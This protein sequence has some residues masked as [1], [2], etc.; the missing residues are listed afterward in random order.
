MRLLK[1]LIHLFFW[2]FALTSKIMN[3]AWK[4]DRL[5]GFIVSVI[6]LPI[7]GPYIVLL[8][9]IAVVVQSVRFVQRQMIFARC[10]EEQR[11]ALNRL[12]YSI[13]SF[14]WTSKVDADDPRIT[15]ISDVEEAVDLCIVTG[16]AH[17]DLQRYVPLHWKRIQQRLAI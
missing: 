6:L 5:L 3:S 4:F 9:A 13:S 15:D 1:L 16:V 11:E 7:W 17:R 2:P 12:E 14:R 10:T 8:A